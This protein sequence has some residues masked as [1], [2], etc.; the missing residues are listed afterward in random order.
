[1]QPGEGAAMGAHPIRPARL[2]YWV[3]GAV[4]VAAVLWFALGLFLGFRAL[5]RQVDGFQRVPIPGR[6]EVSF[7]ESGGYTLYYEGVGASDEQ[8]TIPSFTVS[9]TSVA[10]GEEVS[11]RDFGGSATYGVAGHSGRALGT[12]RIEE[13]GR[14]LLQTE[15]EPQTGQANVAVGSSVGP[16]IFRTVSL[17]IVGTLILLLGG[18]VLAVVVA[19]RR[20][21]ARRVLLA[22]AAQP[23]ASRG[24]STAPAGWFADPGRRHELRYW[25]DQ[26][27]TEHVSDRG[28]QGVDPI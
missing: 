16:A 27:W 7:E 21:R 4:A 11:I 24:Q 6:G 18:A 19:V 5:S 12:F 3:A 20:N 9:L 23:V 1:M 14:F 17:A 2:W 25:D 22:P 28:T 8:V 26:R 15:G 10:S 13:P